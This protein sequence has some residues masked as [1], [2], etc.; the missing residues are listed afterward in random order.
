[1]TKRKGNG[2][3][4]GLPILDR[5]WARYR[6]IDPLVRFMIAH[7][8]LGAATGI[9]C[10]ALL[11]LIDPFGLRPLIAGSD[12]AALAVALL[13]FGFASTFGGLVC[14]AAVMFPDGYFASDREPPQGGAKA[15]AVL[16]PALAR[17]AARR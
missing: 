6:R 12:T 14:A 10:A 15:P 5:V 7:W 2:S 1:M 4:R 17:I 9:V 3:R 13:G 11:L 8:V 16:R